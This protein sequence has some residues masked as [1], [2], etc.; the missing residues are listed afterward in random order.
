[1][2]ASLDHLNLTVRDFDETVAWYARVFGFALVE[3]GVDEQGPWGVLR[4]GDS[5]LCVYERARRAAPRSGPEAERF[6]LVNHFGLRLAPEERARWERTVREEGLRTYH[7][8]PLRYPYSTSW[9]VKDPSGHMIEV[10]VWDD[11]RVAFAGSPP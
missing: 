5:M 8:S 4:S 1:M 11:D 2:N 7:G 10:A 3:R 6:H 9:Y